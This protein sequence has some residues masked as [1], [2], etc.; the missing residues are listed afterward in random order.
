MNAPEAP[1]QCPERPGVEDGDRDRL[2]ELGY[3]PELPHAQPGDVVIYGLIYM[4][5]LAPIGVFGSSTTCRPGR[6]P[7]CTWSPRSRCCSAPSAT[8]RWPRCSRSPARPTAMSASGTNRFLGFVSGWAILLDYLLLP[9][10][11]CVFA[12]SAMTTV[13]PSVPAWMWVVFFVAVTAVTNL[14]GMTVTA[15]MNK[16]LPLHPA[17]HL[18]RVPAGRRFWSSRAR[19]H[20]TL[21]PFHPHGARSWSVVAVRFPSRPS[22]SWGSTPSRP[23]TRRPR[24]EARPC[25]RRRCSSCTSSTALFVVQVYFACILVPNG[26]HSPTGPRPTTPSTTWS[27][28]HGQQVQDVHRADSAPVRGIGQHHGG[29]RHRRAAGVQHG[30]RRPAAEVVRAG[31]GKHKVPINAMI[32]IA[33]G[34]RDRHSRR[35]QSSLLTTLVTFGALPRTSCSTSA[36]SPTS[37]PQAEAA[38]FSSTGS[39]RSSAPRSSWSRCGTRTPTPR[40]SARAGSSSASVWRRTSSS[41]GVRSV[42]PTPDRTRA[43]RRAAQASA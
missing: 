18:G 8:R 29:Q 21:D 15:K 12:A 2:R 3:E 6:S 9:A 43:Y 22:A 19:A 11:L 27:G 1:K 30:A 33:A 20:L 5:P 26:T 38:A 40:S 4:V 25:R 31:S 16:I 7:R 34:A 41:P 35:E 23:S 36:S 28:R 13:V 14:L 37:S 39:P 32:I 24:A 10:L 17:R 42:A